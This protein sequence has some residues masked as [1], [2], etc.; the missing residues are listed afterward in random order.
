[1]RAWYASRPLLCLPL[2]VTSVATSLAS[3]QAGAQ[4]VAPID[5]NDDARILAAYDAATRGDTSR[6]EQMLATPGKHPLEPY[7][8]YWLL[9]TRVARIGEPL[10]MQAIRDFLQLNDGTLVAERLRAD[11]LKRLG[12]EGQWQIFNDEYARLQQP[13]AE[14][15]CDA[16]KA[17]GSA[18]EPALKMLEAQWQTLGDVM[19]ACAAP[20][21]MLVD[22]GRKSGEDIQWRL[23]RMVELNK[24]AAA[25]QTAAMLP[26]GLA[27][28]AG[29]LGRAFDNPLQYLASPAAR[30]AMSRPARE[31]VLA[32]VA[33]AARS[34][35]RTT[36]TRWR[37]LE[38]THYSAAERG[39]AI[40]QIAWGA[41]LAQ[42]PEA[43]QWFAS[44][45]EL[46]PGMPMGDEQMA[47][48]MRS[49]LRA[50][51]W[52]A[53]QAS[54]DAMTQAQRNL[55][56]WTYWQGRALSQQNKTAEA[57]VFYE[58]L[59]GEPHFYGILSAEALGRS[60]NWPLAAV[61]PTVLEMSRV[62]ENVAVQRALALFRLDQRSLALR[63]WSWGM[64]GADDRTL[65]ATSDY[66]RRMGLFDRAINAA[67]RTRQ[68]HDYSLRY[69][70]PYYDIF[71][72]ESRVRGLDLHWVYGLTRQESRF[73]PV[74]RS[75]V[76]AQGLMQIMPATG[77]MV[78]RQVGMQGFSV[79]L[80][81]QTEPNIQLGTAYLR[82]VLDSLYSSPVMAT[83][84]YN[85]GPGRA[86]RWRDSKP[87]E[88]AIYA[89][90]IPITETRDYVK[91]VMANAVAY[92][93]VLDGKPVS[94]TRLLGT[95]P[96]EA[97]ADAR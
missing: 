62:E 52:T 27:P 45:R 67:E 31:L 79:S 20:L 75:S 46:A 8:G 9:T 29:A 63:E 83:A 85:A 33:R 54:L 2:L 22:A 64:R 14:L 49:A 34:D 28:D 25:R 87:L 60:I 39:Y 95:V 78:A 66:A 72:R 53:V 35:A 15:L 23:R 3:A 61:P 90:S 65:L 5:R 24:L 73:D 58:R 43:V 94:L 36:L 44:A 16:V 56:E 68:Q 84:G 86:K 47:W 17:R 93:V 50:G 7:V 92:A 69:L 30:G 77:K 41:A 57:R 97:L 19:D 6:L 18:A 51:D 37:A 13:D 82:S 1:M 89:E 55:P 4:P 81:A 76:G 88:G 32:A 80:L 11:W 26:D 10:P 42:M 40:G 38:D 96:G 70:A 48:Q 21:Q 74:A 12:R 59:A 71:S 91:K